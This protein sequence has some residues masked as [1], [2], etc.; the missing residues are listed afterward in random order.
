MKMGTNPLFSSRFCYAQPQW[1]ILQQSWQAQRALLAA[2]AAA[3]RQSCSLAG[4][5]RNQQHQQ[6]QPPNNS[7]I[8]T[9]KVPEHYNAAT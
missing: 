1:G 2:A 9:S 4:S 7:C 5:A 8:N 6:Q 3:G